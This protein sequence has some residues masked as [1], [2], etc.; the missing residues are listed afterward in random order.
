MYIPSFVPSLCEAAPTHV[1]L[2]KVSSPLSLPRIPCRTSFSILQILLQLSLFACAQT[3]T[4]THT[5]LPLWGRFQTKCNKQ[6]LTFV[7]GKS[8]KY[9]LTKSLPNQGSNCRRIMPDPR[10]AVG[11]VH[12]YECMARLGYNSQGCARGQLAPFH[13]LPGGRPVSAHPSLTTAAPVWEKAEPGSV[14]TAPH[15]AHSFCSSRRGLRPVQAQGDL[16]FHR[17]Q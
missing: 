16:S 1:H 10:Q 3:H 14:P 13:R 11:M 9:Y 2:Q 17:Q 8:P 5:L 12:N 15:S 4:H 7:H 6:C